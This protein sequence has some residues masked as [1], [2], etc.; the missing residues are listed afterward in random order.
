M[1]VS[2]CPICYAK[3]EVAEVAPCEECGHLEEEIEHML[4]GIHTYDEVRIFGELTLILCNFCQVD[5]G[6]YHPEFFGLPP[7]SKIGFEK[8]QFLRSI[9]NY[10]VKKDKVCPNCYHRI[11]FL[12]FVSQA[13]ELHQQNDG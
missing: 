10:S 8:M 4:K 13:R 11:Q 3:L 1:K 2:Y 12:E 7:D 6:S 9:D 5:F